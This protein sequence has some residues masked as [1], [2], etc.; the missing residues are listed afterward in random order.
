M[1]ANQPTVSETANEK[2]PVAKDMLNGAS[3]I[4]QFLGWTRRRLY[5]EA[6]SDRIRITRLP[7]FRIGATLSARKSSLLRW[8][9]DQE[10]AALQGAQQ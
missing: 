1:I 10:A 9:A 4:A 7:V 5:Y 3:A 2:S 8:I 6:G